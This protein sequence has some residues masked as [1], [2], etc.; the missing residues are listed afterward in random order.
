VGSE[1][2]ILHAPTIGASAAAQLL[3]E[4]H[5]GAELRDE[6]TEALLEATSDQPRQGEIDEFRAEAKRLRNERDEL[7]KQ[8]HAVT[9]GAPVAPDG[10]V[11][12]RVD[13]IFDGGG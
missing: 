5:P 7:R 13:D 9:G 6:A 8:L 4:R 1:I 10:S 3:L 2:L 12:V 11:G